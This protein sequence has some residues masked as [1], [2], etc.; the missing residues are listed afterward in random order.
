MEEDKQV[1][2]GFR[3]PQSKLEE[4][5]SVADDLGVLPTTVFRLAIT[6]YLKGKAKGV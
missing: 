6:E 5:R 4:I 3:L 1:M 2:I